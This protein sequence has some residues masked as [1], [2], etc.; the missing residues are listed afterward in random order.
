MYVT[1]SFIGGS[2]KV[3]NT[4]ELAERVHH[5]RYT[6]TAEER[7]GSSIQSQASPAS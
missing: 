3:W 4:V 7:D 1:N 6:D 2:Q 5:G